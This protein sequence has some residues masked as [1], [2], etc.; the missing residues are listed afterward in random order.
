[1][2]EQIVE[3]YMNL[4]SHYATRSSYNKAQDQVN[5]ALSV[6]PGNTDA[7]AMRA[8]IQDAASRGLGWY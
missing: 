1:M 8:R 6:D 7:L 5:L 2:N 3:I 4:A